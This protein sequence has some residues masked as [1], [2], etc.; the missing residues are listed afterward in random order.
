MGTQ[1]S[2]PEDD[3]RRR[4]DD[5][6]ALPD[7]PRGKRTSLSFPH[8][9]IVLELNLSN[10]EDMELEAFSDDTP[11]T[12]TKQLVVR[13]SAELVYSDIIAIRLGAQRLELSTPLSAAGVEDGAVLRVEL[14]SPTA[15]EKREHEAEAERA[16]KEADAEAEQ[17]RLAA[18]EAELEARRKLESKLRVGPCTTQQ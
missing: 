15:A 13:S 14:K 4:P 12:V 17:A 9:P 5:L 10:G 3:A 1:C 2:R 6:E 11:D 8:L 18:I 16:R 7:P